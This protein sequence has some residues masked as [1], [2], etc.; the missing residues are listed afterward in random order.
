MRTPRLLVSLVVA[1]A[2]L[3]PMALAQKAE[4]FNP[5]PRHFPTKQRFVFEFAA[6]GG[7]NNLLYHNGPVLTNA[8]VIPIYWG[9]TW[10]AGAATI[11]YRPLL[12]ATLTETAQ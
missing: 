4:P 7:S 6:R 11:R 8:Y 10:A 3:V 1:A 12:T 2:S 5:L 9:P